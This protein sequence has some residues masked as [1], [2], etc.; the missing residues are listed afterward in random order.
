M[1]SDILKLKLDVVLYNS[2]LW[3]LMLANTDYYWVSLVI[4]TLFQQLYYVL[5]II[6]ILELAPVSK[7]ATVQ[8]N[9]DKC[10]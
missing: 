3:W 8:F 5:D 1:A 7:V 9:L 10:R 6:I 2:I 4:L